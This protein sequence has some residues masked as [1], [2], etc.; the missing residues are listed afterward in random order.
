MHRFK[1]SVPWWAKI[2]GKITLSR[3]RLPYTFWH[4]LGLFRHGSMQDPDYAL[5]VFMRHFEAVQS[6]LPANFSLLEL[7]P[8][9]SLATALL[10]ASRG[11]AQIWLVDAGAFA[12]TDVQGYTPLQQ[13]LS[14]PWN[15]MHFSSLT[16][17]LQATNTTYLTQGVDSLR[18]IPSGSVDFVFSQAVLEHI[19]LYEFDET[20]AELFRIQRPGSVASHRIDF[21][22]HL[23]HSLNS[24]RFSER[25]WESPLFTRSGFYTN[26]LRAGQVVSILQ[27]VGYEVIDRM[28]DKWASLPIRR[29]VMASPFDSM[30]DDDL[31][32]RGMDLRLRKPG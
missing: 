10:G 31:C 23:E 18:T 12:A 17:M 5:R 26:R 24:L 1:E 22:D 8:G 11:A 32:V 28:D 14:P 3:V 25:V 15:T 20:M 7:G 13:R 19:P 6:Y 4:T 16:T 27:N 2:I 29:T 30:A 21:Q 9:D